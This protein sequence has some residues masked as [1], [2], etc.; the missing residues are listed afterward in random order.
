MTD[1]QAKV[2]PQHTLLRRVLTRILS[3][4]IFAAIVGWIINF[5][6]HFANKPA[7]P[8]GFARG[9]VHGALM[10][11]ALPNLVIGNDVPIYAANNTGRTYKLGYTVGVNGCGL[12]FF[13]VFF[14]RVNR[15][16]KKQLSGGAQVLKDRGSP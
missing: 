16:R 15:W 12:I 5:A 4:L 6:I 8:A 11:A 3:F 14:W 13:G 7:G 1:T 9:I 10:P 2:A